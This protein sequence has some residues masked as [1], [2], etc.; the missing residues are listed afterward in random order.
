MPMHPAFRGHGTFC[1]LPDETM[2][3]YRN[4]PVAPF[5]GSG[6][7][8]SLRGF[9]NFGAAPAA[10][11]PDG[12]VRALKDMDMSH[13][14]VRLFGLEGTMDPVQTRLLVD[15]LKAANVH[16]AGWGY[17]HGKDAQKE[18][19]TAID[20]CATFGL[21]AFV[22]DVEPGRLLGGTRSKWEIDEFG[23]FVDG[24]VDNFGRDNVGISTWPVLKIQNEA[25]FPSLKLM[26]HVA[27]RVAMFAPQAY[28]MTYPKQVHYDATGFKE[29]NYPKNDPAS[30]A[31]LVVDSWRATGFEQPLV[32][33]GQAYWGEG[34]P[35]QSIVE[36]KLKTFATTYTA[37]SKII[38]L[39]WW[40][41]GGSKAMS[42]AMIDTLVSAKLGLK[43]FASPDPPIA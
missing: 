41:A 30:F 42:P 8:N 4:Y 43:P 13:V 26:K 10:V 5:D 23:D 19:Q 3:H 33:T 12:F 29:A 25:D 7:F 14:W 21:T 17:C 15:A 36:G 1:Y 39:N 2:R 22:A 18:M 38:G 31:R 34:A 27:D 35:A 9:F 20:Q 11:S 24:L 40:H 16:V 6:F 37:W 32:L 28:W